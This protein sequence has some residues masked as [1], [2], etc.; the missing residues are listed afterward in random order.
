MA[1][2]NV[3]EIEAALGA[4]AAEH[5]HVTELIALP[6]KSPENRSCHALRIGPAD[7]LDVISLLAIGG[8]HAREWVPPD[9]LV[10]LAADL[11]EAHAAGTGLRYGGQSFSRDEMQSLIAGLQIVVFPCVNPDGRHHSQTGDPMWRKN[12]RRIS[13]NPNPSCVGV[14]LNRNFDALWDFRRH[15]AADFGV[16]ASDD[17]CNFQ[18]Y[19]GPAA[20]SEPETQNVVALFERYPNARWFI[21]VHAYVPAIYHGWG[22]DE[23]QTSD[24]SMNFLNPAFDGQ[25]GRAGD[26]YREFIDAADLTAVQALGS[27]MN[28]AITAASVSGAGYELGQAFSLYPTSG[29]SDDYASARHFV[30]SS[31]CKVLGF[32]VECG[33]SFQPTWA[34]GE[35]VIRELCAGLVAFSLAAMQQAGASTGVAA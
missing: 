20:A 28:D 19:V 16:S 21:D 33:T 13:A 18:V 26:A 2:M 15:F 30:D 23:N 34:E 31:K 24:P 4:L 3:D 6:H 10:N 12:R 7:G 22:F 5:P 1:Y 25:R 9:A 35:D 17:P 11:V 32:T 29:A 8:L 14:D 27:R